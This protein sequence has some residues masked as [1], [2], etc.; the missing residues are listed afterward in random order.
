MLV[1]PRVLVLRKLTAEVEGRLA[2]TYE[3]VFSLD[4]KP[5]VPEAIAQA[6]YDYE[7]LVPT[8]SDRITAVM[9]KGAGV[10]TRMIANVGVGYSNI[11]VAAARDAGIA[12]SNTPDVL[13]DATADTAL[14]LILSVTRRAFAAEKMLRE[15]RWGGFSIVGG[16]GASI[17]DKVL[18]I[19]GMGRIGQ[20]VARRA[21][22]GFGMKIVYYNRS[23]VSGLG[24]EAQGL[25]SIDAV[26]AVADVVSVHVPGGGGTPLVTAAH[27]ARMKPS[28]YLVNTARGDSLDQ[29][30][31]IA[32]L[33]E[34][35][36]AGAGFDVFAKEPEVP[37][38]LRKMENVTL[39]PHIGSAT[40][41]VRTAMGHMA[42]DNL[43]AYFEGRALP[44]R[45]V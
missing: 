38:T 45:V 18:G 37:E 17:Q 4:D 15:G 6:L 26:M 14:L 34:K 11:D 20:A 13:T 39:L 28:A 9:L 35:R 21:A 30:A 8:V 29:T 43:D 10:R 19:I 24:F 16:L 2:K 32:A 23:P 44:S 33:A 1:K 12:V 5:M 42:V 40:E 25:D 7:A 27:I 41:E 22:L 3:A 31:L 36:I